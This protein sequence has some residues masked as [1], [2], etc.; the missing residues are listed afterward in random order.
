MLSLVLGF[1]LVPEAMR[2]YFE[3]SS[4]LLNFLRQPEYPTW[5]IHSFYG[6]SVLLFDELN[7][8][9]TNISTYILSGGTILLLWQ[10]WKNISWVGDQRAWDL[11]IAITFIWGLLISPH[12]F[13][14]DLMLL[15][16]PAAIVIHHLPWLA[17]QDKR[18]LLWT[19]IVWIACFVGNVSSFA[20]S[21][22]ANNFDLSVS[23]LQFSTLIIFFWGYRLLSIT[24]KS[25]QHDHP[26]KYFPVQAVS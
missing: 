1:I 11:A 23:S 9:L 8:I 14:Y 26:K 13:Y 4:N 20:Q 7:P 21:I 5:G 19:L 12:L 15:L 16:L 17:S 22:L 18:L 6:F 10:L 25:R 24:L 3:I 2:A